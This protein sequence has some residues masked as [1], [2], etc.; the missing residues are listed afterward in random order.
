MPAFPGTGSGAG[1]GQRGS[2][3]S[4]EA[5]YPDSMTAAST[6]ALPVDEIRDRAAARQ[7]RPGYAVA[8]VIA[9]VCSALGWL[10]GRSLVVLG[11]LAGRAW[12]ALCFMAEA[13]T[14]GFKQGSMPK[15]PLPEPQE[16]AR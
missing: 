4:R 12:L 13:V 5:R 14:W 2:G 11:W 6:R 10:L 7:F 3:G 9:A 16:K 8:T 1:P 15:T